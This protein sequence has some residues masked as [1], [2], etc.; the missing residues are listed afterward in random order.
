MAIFH[1][2][3]SPPNKF[4]TGTITSSKYISAKPGS[5]SSCGIGRTVTPGKSKGTKMNE[6]PLCLSESRSVLNRP[7][8]QSAYAALDDQV[9]WPFIL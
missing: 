2:S 4:S 3:P 1:P 7:N 6:R 9:F 5:P 8:V